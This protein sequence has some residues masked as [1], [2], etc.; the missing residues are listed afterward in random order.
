MTLQDYIEILERLNSVKD[1]LARDEDFVL[2][3]DRD[4]GYGIDIGNN[5][6]R[7]WKQQHGLLYYFNCSESPDLSVIENVFQSLKDRT[8]KQAVWDLATLKTEIIQ[9]WEEIP[10]KWINSLVDSMPQRLHDVIAA[11]GAMTGW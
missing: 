3:E 8:K 10:Q 4:G 5:I 1:W 9:A 6:V 11:E 2:E 7:T